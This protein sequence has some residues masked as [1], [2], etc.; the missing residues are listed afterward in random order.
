VKASTNVVWIRNCR[1]APWVSWHSEDT[2]DC[3]ADDKISYRSDLKWWRLRLFEEG[4]PQEEE[5]EQQVE[6]WY[7]ISP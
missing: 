4:C 3:W 1:S 5:E 7:W 6:Y 2:A